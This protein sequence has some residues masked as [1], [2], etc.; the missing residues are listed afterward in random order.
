MKSSGG[1]TVHGVQIPYTM[2]QAG[3]A[4][5][6]RDPK[7]FQ[8]WMVRSAMTNVPTT[9]A[10]SL[11]LVDEA[12]NRLLQRERRAGRIVYY[13]SLWML[14]EAGRRAAGCNMACGA[15]Q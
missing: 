14:T 4:R 5:M 10:L 11:D 13:C 7:G 3:L 15:V 2:L 12:A 8:A 6:R 1:M 9:P